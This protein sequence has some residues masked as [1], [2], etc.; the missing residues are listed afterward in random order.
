M[1][2]LMIKMREDN[3]DEKVKEITLYIPFYVFTYGVSK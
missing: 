2:A 1:Y 3:H